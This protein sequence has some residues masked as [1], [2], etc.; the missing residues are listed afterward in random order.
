MNSSF[1]FSFTWKRKMRLHRKQKTQVQ[2]LT[3]D[4]NSFKSK[5]YY[6]TI[7]ILH[8]HLITIGDVVRVLSIEKDSF[9]VSLCKFLNFIVE[10]RSICYNYLVYIR[11]QLSLCPLF[12]IIYKKY[13]LRLYYGH[14][15]HREHLVVLK[16]N[17]NFVT[18]TQ[19]HY[20]FALQK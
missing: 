11:W 12:I 14:W 2:K 15:Y 16:I 4:S 7:F 6:S 1:D 5:A 20:C 8:V 19:K 17:I 13:K 9:W 3:I 10:S 18:F